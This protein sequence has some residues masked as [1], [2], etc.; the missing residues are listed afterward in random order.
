MSIYKDDIDNMFYVK[1]FFFS[2]SEKSDIR[3]DR[4]EKVVYKRHGIRFECT[5]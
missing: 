3:G 5:V 4:A 2:V 1:Y